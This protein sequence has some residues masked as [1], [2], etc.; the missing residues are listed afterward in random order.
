MLARQLG[1]QP[2]DV[3]VGAAD[4]DHRASVDAGGEDLLLLE[5]GGDEDVGSIPAAAAWAAT[6][7]ARL[8]VDAQASVSKPSSRARASATAT[9]RSLNE[10]VGLAASFLTHTSPRPRR[11]ASRSARTSGVQP[12]GSARAAPRAGRCLEGQEVGVAPDVLGPALDAAAQRAASPRSRACRR[13]RAGRSTARRRSGRRAAYS[14]RTFLAL[15]RIY[16]HEK[17]LCPG[18]TEV[19]ED[20]STTSPRLSLEPVRN[21]HL[22]RRDARVVAGAS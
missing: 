17:N 5:V 10:C 14:V 15:Q 6:A 2:V 19:P 20:R 18:V 7:F 3:V 22:S 12:A 11:S 16:G 21:W 8:P 9:T 4:G 1:A 13:P